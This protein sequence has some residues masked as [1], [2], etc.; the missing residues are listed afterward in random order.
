MFNFF[1]LIGGFSYFEFII[2]G[3][4]GISLK[5]FNLCFFFYDFLQSFFIILWGELSSFYLKS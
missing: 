1:D 3:L 2:K 4:R 5:I